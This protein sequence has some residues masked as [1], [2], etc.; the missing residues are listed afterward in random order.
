MSDDALGDLCVS[1]LESLVPD[2]RSRYLGCRV[3]R[4]PIAYPVFALEYEDDRRKL[5]A[6]GGIAGLHLIGRNGEFRHDLMEDVYW[7]TL[8]R[9]E[10]IV[11]EFTADSRAF[12]QPIAT[13]R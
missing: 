4:T 10:R 13:S 1:H 11:A 5:P 8:A 12:S 7:R 2:I 9:A 6:A 3:M